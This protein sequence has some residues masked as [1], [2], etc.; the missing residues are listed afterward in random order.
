MGKVTRNYW[1]DLGVTC[2]FL[3]VWWGCFHSFTALMT[4]TLSPTPSLYPSLAAFRH[5]PWKPAISPAGEAR[6]YVLGAIRN[7]SQPAEQIVQWKRVGRGRRHWAVAGETSPGMRNEH[8]RRRNTC[9]LRGREGN[10]SCVEGTGRV[11]EDGGGQTA[12]RWRGSMDVCR[13]VKDH[14]LASSHSSPDNKSGV[15]SSHEALDIRVITDHATA[16]WL[17]QLFTILQY[18]SL[19]WQLPNEESRYAQCFEFCLTQQRKFK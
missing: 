18:F 6:V 11:K 10:L 17:G 13:T 1:I 8:R 15:T 3:S 9:V 14:L 16:G 12:G 2:A 19:L 5:S 7:S 4:V